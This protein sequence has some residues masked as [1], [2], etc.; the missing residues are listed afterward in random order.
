[1]LDRDVVEFAW[2]L[3]I[4]YKRSDGVSKRILRNALYK[5]VPKELMDRPKKGFSIPIT[6]WLKEE[7]LRKW[8]EELLNSDVIRRQGILDERVVSKLWREF[9]EKDNWRIQIWYILM[10]QVWINENEDLLT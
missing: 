6:K 5:R 2:T 10:F 1:M 9:I 3:P 8:A 7:G 4:E